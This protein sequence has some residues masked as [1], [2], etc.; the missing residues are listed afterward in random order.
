MKKHIQLSLILAI[1]YI[2]SVKAQ[3]TYNFAKQ[4]QSDA[5]GNEYLYSMSSDA[6]NNIYMVGKFTGSSLDFNFDEDATNAVNSSCGFLVKYNSD[7]IYQWAVALTGNATTYGVSVDKDGNSYLVGYFSGTVDFNPGAGTN[8][9]TAPSG[10]LAGFF[11]K[12]DA[13]GVFQWSKMITG[14]SGGDVLPLAVAST[15]THLL[16]TG[17]YSAT[18]ADFDPDAGTALFSANSFSNDLFVAKYSSSDGSYAGAFSLGDTGSET[19]YSI[20]VDASENAIIGGTFQGT[21]DFDPGTGTS[22][23]TATSTETGFIMKVSPA[24]AV[25]AV[26]LLPDVFH[27]KADASDNIH[28]LG[29]DFLAKYDPAGTLLW[30]NN[31]GSPMQSFTSGNIVIESNGDVTMCGA[32]GGKLAGPNVYTQMSG[33]GYFAKFDMNGTLITYKDMGVPCKGLAYDPSGNMIIVGHFNEPTD[34]DTRLTSSDTLTPTYYDVFFAKYNACSGYETSST[35][36]LCQGQTVSYGVHSYTAVGSQVYYAKNNITLSAIDVPA[37]FRFVLT[38]VNGCDSVVTVTLSTTIFNTSLTSNA[39][40]LT[41]NTTGATYQWLDCL[42]GSSVIAGETSI[43]FAPT[44]SGQYSVEMTKNGCKDT[45]VCLNK[46][47]VTGLFDNFNEEVISVY[48]NPVVDQI[49]INNMN[50]MSN[51]HTI[52]L[53]NG[54]GKIILEKKSDRQNEVLDVEKLPYGIYILE[55]ETNGNYFRKSILKARK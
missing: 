36:N 42:N 54:Q 22:N 39:S 44:V 49:V 7:G 31:L 46:A 38:A 26:T 5:G 15:S 28:I 43:S 16:I 19:G 3:Y 48:P 25:S 4:T 55:I 23:L 9:M 27:V 10:S 18:N 6:S 52:R 17:R 51:T 47:A 37:D 41:C 2:S 45:S 29:K 13:S 8:N 32:G 12:Y 33:L 34:F 14:T 20:T 21:V 24:G 11:A 35:V 50:S 53:L 30:K 40:G 1:L